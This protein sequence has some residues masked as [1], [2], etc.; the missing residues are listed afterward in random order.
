MKTFIALLR[1]VNV[2]GRKPLP[3]ADLRA[4][5]S[6]LGCVEV[7]SVLQTGNLVFGARAQP[8]GQLER[9]FDSEAK[10]RLG[11]DTDFFVRD[12][13]D[14]RSVLADNPFAREA[15]RDPAHLLVLFTMQAPAPSAVQALREAITGRE[16]VA[17]AG[18]HV[19]AVYPDGIGRSKLTVALI[20]KKLGTRCTGRNWNTVLKLGEVAED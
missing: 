12:A 19:Y 9:L 1:A 10:K 16:T 18:R 3:M 17:A 6:G 14:W 13:A 5:A 7:R 4:L 20:E 2:G 8:A 11:L 15:A